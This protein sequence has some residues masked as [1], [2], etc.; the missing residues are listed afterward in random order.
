LAEESKKW[1]IWDVYGIY[2]GD[3]ERRILSFA[4]KVTLLINYWISIGFWLYLNLHPYKRTNCF[5]SLPSPLS[6]LRLYKESGVEKC[7]ENIPRE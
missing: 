1:N 6:S 7:N 5:S 4:K 2:I 3:L